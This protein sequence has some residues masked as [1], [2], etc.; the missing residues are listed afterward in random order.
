M[1][2]RHMLVSHLLRPTLVFLLVAI[3][4]EFSGVDL[5]LGDAIY[6]WSGDSWRWRDAW[7]TATLVHEYGRTLV[8]GLVLVLLLLIL[9]SWQVAVLSPFR[10]GL[11]YVLVSALLAGL[12]VNIGKRLT[13]VDCPWDLLR[14]G[15]TAD[16]VRN[17]MSHADTG[18]VGGCFP[19]GHASAGYGWFGL[20]YF[21]RQFW[22]RWRSAAL[23]GVLLLGLVFGIGQQLRGAH[24]LSHDVWTLGICWLVATTLALVWF[25][26]GKKMAAMSQA[27]AV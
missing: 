22:P 24:F 8:A 4:L 14:Y 6:H 10:S 27:L 5:W 23:A 15:G 20:Y 25:R 19:A 12:V 26:P 3:W 21:V 9:A 1:V 2:V 7:V 18:G 17:F 16:Y 11:C 13:H